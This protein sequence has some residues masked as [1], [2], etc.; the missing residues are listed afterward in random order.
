[1]AKMARSAGSGAPGITH[2][3]LQRRTGTSGL[4]RSHR[5]GA[6]WGKKICQRCSPDHV[7]SRRTKLGR[8]GH[9]ESLESTKSWRQTCRSPTS[10]YSD[11]AEKLRERG[12]GKGEGKEGKYGASPRGAVGDLENEREEEWGIVGSFWAREAVGGRG[13]T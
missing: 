2:R 1:M 8:R 5:S 10:K 12:E 9:L 11:L 3:S 6:H 4:G 7:E 13:R